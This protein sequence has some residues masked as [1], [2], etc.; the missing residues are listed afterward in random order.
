MEIK[1]Y[2]DTYFTSQVKSLLTRIY[3]RS[4]LNDS[5]LERAVE[6]YEKQPF[7]QH[8][9]DE[10]K[11]NIEKISAQTATDKA[12]KLLLRLQREQRNYHNELR[13]ER[14][15]R[16]HHLY[17]ICEEIIKLSEGDCFEESNR[18]SAQLLGTIQLVSPTQGRKIALTNE[19]HKPLYKSVLCLRL[20]DRLCMDKH[21]VEPYIKDALADTNAEQY[22]SLAEDNPEVYQAFVENIKVPLVMAA[23]LQ[24]IGNNHPASLAILYGV[25][26]QQNPHRTLPIEERKA[27]LQ[28]NYRETVKYLIDGIGAAMYIG[29]SKKDRDKHND[30]EHKKLL[31]IKHLLKSA[32]NPKE[33]IGNLLKVPQI[34]SSIILSTKDSYN[35]KLLPKVYQVLNQNAERGACS[36][37]VVNALTK[38]TGHF[39]QGYGVTYIPY[40][41]DINDRY[42]YAIVSQLYPDHA[43]QPICRTATRNLAFIS[44]GQVIAIKKSANLYFT[45]TAK[46]FSTITKERL[47]E[48]LEL[49]VSNSHERKQLDLLPRCWQPGEFFTININQKLWNKGK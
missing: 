31:F 18:K 42:E 5:V 14:N 32:V 27:L 6:Y 39:P 36:Q 41:Q 8:K 24:D 16:H 48:I 26:Y 44:Y 35:Y 37:R 23:L 15:D 21:I 33:G 1:T 20:L 9:L 11:K 28:I 38:I 30:L 29:N 19:Q 49:L 12:K 25:D 2:T 10:L 4:Q 40:D 3:G 34:Y 45:K 43:D 13:F 7:I 47:H 46:S 22:Q 17:N